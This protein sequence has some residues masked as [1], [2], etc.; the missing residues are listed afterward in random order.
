M[1]D[2]DARSLAGLAEDGDYRE[3]DHVT[4][5]TDR[6]RPLVKGAL[7]EI[8]NEFKTSVESA[9]ICRKKHVLKNDLRHGYLHTHDE[10][11]PFARYSPAP[12]WQVL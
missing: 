6:G 3:N 1:C 7:E 4:V 11:H 10:S 12:L 8:T 5:N 2:L 9:G